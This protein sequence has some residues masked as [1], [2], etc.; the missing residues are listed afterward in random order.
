MSI[1]QSKAATSKSVATMAGVSVATVSRVINNL[2]NVQK[3]TKDKVLAAIKA[4]DYQPNLAA[5]Q[6]ARQRVH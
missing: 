1:I 6:M 4:L 3:R 5:Q 2:P